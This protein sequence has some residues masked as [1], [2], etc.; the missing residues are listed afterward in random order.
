MIPAFFHRLPGDEG[1]AFH[2]HPALDTDDAELCA[3]RW[4]A[5][6]EGHVT[7]FP[8]QYLWGHRMFKTRPDGE[9]SPYAESR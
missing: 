8:E 6:L 4:Y 5:L 9:P 7:R 3:R 1:Y 2:Y